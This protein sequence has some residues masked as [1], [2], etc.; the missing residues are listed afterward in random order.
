MTRKKNLR[1][2]DSN[3]SMMKKISRSGRQWLIVVGLMA[4]FDDDT[5]NAFFEFNSDTH[6]R[7]DMYTL[8]PLITLIVLAFSFFR[9]FAKMTISHRFKDSG[10]TEQK[11][12]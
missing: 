11:N 5:N 3:A 10:H 1:F 8:V 7:V 12:N 2:I 9:P 4:S 6:C